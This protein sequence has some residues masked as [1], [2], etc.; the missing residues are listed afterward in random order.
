M[1]GFPVSV[2]DKRKIKSGEA[3]K[4]HESESKT[5]QGV[6]PQPPRGFCAISLLPLSLEQ[7]DGRG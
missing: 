6:S 2:S 4:R 7:T 5:R 1:P 3:A